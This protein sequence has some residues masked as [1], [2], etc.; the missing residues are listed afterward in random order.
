M[1]PKFTR[2]GY[3]RNGGTLLAPDLCRELG[4][5]PGQVLRRNPHGGNRLGRS[6]YVALREEIDKASMFEEIVGTSPAL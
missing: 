3:H 5:V 4:K 2:G 6:R 1:T